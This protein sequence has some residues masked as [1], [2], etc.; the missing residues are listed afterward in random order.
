MYAIRSYYGYI[1][2]K[3]QVDDAKG[4]LHLCVLIILAQI[5]TGAIWIGAVVG[6]LFFGWLT[7]RLGRKKLFFITLSVYLVATAATAFSIPSKPS[8]NTSNAS[9]M[10]RS[11]VSSDGSRVV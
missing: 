2:H 11:R 6:A 8:D 1:I 3:C 10:N 7:D 5:P 9:E 4:R